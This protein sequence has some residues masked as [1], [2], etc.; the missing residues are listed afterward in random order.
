[1]NHLKELAMECGGES[2]SRPPMRAVTGIAFTDQALQMFAEKIVSAA[3]ALGKESMVDAIHEDCLHDHLW[4]LSIQICDLYLG[5]RITGAEAVKLFENLRL[6]YAAQI[7]AK[8]R[9]NPEMDEAL[10][11]LIDAPAVVMRIHALSLIY[12]SAAIMVGTH[13][14]GDAFKAMKKLILGMVDEK[15][16]HH[17]GNGSYELTKPHLDW[18]KWT[19][20]SSSDVFDA[21]PSLDFLLG[22]G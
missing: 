5:G 17:I 10:D 6:G 1:M 18:A 12:A 13:G 15:I 14:N 2:W 3:N 4:S 19:E 8:Y 9:N 16:A 11:K 22:R 7:T 20:F 21:L